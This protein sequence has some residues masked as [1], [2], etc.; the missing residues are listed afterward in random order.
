MKTWQ[1]FLQDVLTDRSIRCPFDFIEFKF[2][3]G[4]EPPW[5]SVSNGSGGSLELLFGDF[6]REI[7][8]FDKFYVMICAV[9]FLDIV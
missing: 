6:R 1:K 3:S 4:V 5:E 8:C 2:G 7:I 9:R